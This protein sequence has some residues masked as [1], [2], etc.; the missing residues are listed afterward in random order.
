M[1][2]NFLLILG[3]VVLSVSLRSFQSIVLQKLGALGIVASS[4]LGGWLFFEN[5]YAGIFLALL[6]FFLPWVEIL[7]R[8]RKL[9]LP[10]EKTL[11][12]KPAPNREA[13]PPLPELTSEVETAGF[14][15]LEDCGWD[16]EDY[17]Q[18]FRLF[19]RESDRTQA[20][21]CLIQQHGVSFYYFS[22]SSRAKD[23]KI[24]T[25]WNYPFSYSLKLVPQWEV[26]RL[27]DDRSFPE[28]Y[29]SH[30]EFLALHAVSAD[31]LEPIDPGQ[32]HAEIQKDLRSQISHNIAT[33]VLRQTASGEV[34]Y[35]W[36]GMLFIWV[37]YL[38]DLV[39]LS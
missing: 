5:I 36:R 2:S 18:F 30:C 35:S 31:S 28:L 34:R 10:L 8:V 32:I 13:F 3:V 26:N 23:G 21:I 24:W 37:Q 20:A 27:R 14:E 29:E 22:I 6:W 16:W 12:Q 19:Y 9:S 33:G 15:H 11:R 17:Q 1:F 39:R 38:R 4:F 7:T 25:T